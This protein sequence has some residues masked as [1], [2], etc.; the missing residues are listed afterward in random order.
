MFRWSQNSVLTVLTDTPSVWLQHYSIPQRC[1]W[2]LRSSEMLCSVYWQSGLFHWWG[3]TLKM[4]AWGCPETS[5]NNYQSALRNIPEE[6]KIS[7]NLSNSP[8]LC[9]NPCFIICLLYAYICFEHYVLI[10]MRS[11]LYYTACG[12][13]TPVGGRQV[14]RTATCRVWWSQML[15]NTVLTSWWWAHSARNT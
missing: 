5:A 8:T 12:I 1:K 6:T 7:H 2:G 10:I 4:G 15:Y 11:K 14:H 13:I 3:R 9:K